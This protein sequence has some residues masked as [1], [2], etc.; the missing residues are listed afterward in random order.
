MTSRLLELVATQFVSVVL[1]NLGHNKP[2]THIGR[3]LPT[4]S[5]KTLMKAKVIPFC[6][7]VSFQLVNFILQERSRRGPK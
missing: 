3:Q 7:H 2:Q 6:T 1:L 4:P 5:A